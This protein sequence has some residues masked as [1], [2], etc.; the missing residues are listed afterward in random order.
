MNLPPFEEAATAAAA[1]APTK[2]QAPP[3]Q[4]PTENL[5]LNPLLGLLN[6]NPCPPAP[7]DGLLNMN[8]CPPEEVSKNDPAVEKKDDLEQADVA[9]TST[10]PPNSNEEDKSTNVVPEETN[11]DI[12]PDEE[13]VDALTDWTN[14]YERVKMRHFYMRVIVFLACTC[15]VTG[16]IIMI[17]GG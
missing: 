9:T 8:P 13:K 12:E 6:M 1:A 14:N 2:E 15:I 11:E 5:L 7:E 4:V 10:V 3:I 17:T 16:S